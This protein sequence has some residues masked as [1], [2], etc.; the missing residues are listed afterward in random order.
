MEQ[1]GLS[2]GMASTNKE[3]KDAKKEQALCIDL[4]I[5]IDRND[6]PNETRR[7]SKTMVG[8]TTRETETMRCRKIE[9]RKRSQMVKKK[10]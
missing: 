4:P 2:L 7:R 9:R 10:V 6:S 8:K 3:K 5:V 1:K